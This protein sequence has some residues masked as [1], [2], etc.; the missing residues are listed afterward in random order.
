MA[1]LGLALVEEA[2]VDEYQ[3]FKWSELLTVIVI[4]LSMVAIGFLPG[5][6]IGLGLAC[7]LF[8]YQG[9]NGRIVRRTLSGKLLRS[10]I[11][12]PARQERVLKPLRSGIVVLQLHG[13]L[14][15]GSTNQLQDAVK[16]LSHTSELP[17]Q[18]TSQASFFA[19]P[20]AV[21]EPDPPLKYLIL[22]FELILD[23]DFSG[24]K[25]VV[26]LPLHH[27]PGCDGQRS[28]CLADCQ[29][30]VLCNGS[31]D[32]WSK[33][34]NA[35]STMSSVP[36]LPS[37][38]AAFEWCENQIICETPGLDR[39]S[40]LT[41]SLSLIGEESAAFAPLWKSE[42]MISGDELWEDHPSQPP[43]AVFVETGELTCNSSCGTVKIKL[44]PGNFAMLA[45][46]VLGEKQEAELVVAS[47][48]ATTL[49]LSFKAW[50][51]LLANQPRLA[52]AVSIVAL[53]LNSLAASGEM[54]WLEA[55]G[56]GEQ[57]CHDDTIASK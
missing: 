4:M 30:M 20:M 51:Q 31:P 57:K 23:A 42:Q 24:C 16:G 43:S 13:H 14:F 34:T 28:N 39:C 1:Q 32:L 25:G 11:R 56:K 29:K 18:L 6:A 5:I 22:D 19:A 7:L 47:L 35:D 12:W 41:S 10:R 49:T 52:L 26:Q 44:I 37:L 54:A 55:S 9:A 2:L 3:A 48:Q 40:S 17:A 46:V 33:L 15:F 27:A 53:R 36:M 8:V 21:L 38:T 50:Q 45:K